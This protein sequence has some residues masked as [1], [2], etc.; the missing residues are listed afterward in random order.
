MLVAGLAVPRL[1]PAV[2]YQH[3][4]SGDYE[5]LDDRGKS[6]VGDG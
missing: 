2:S 1:Y 4:D 3:R 5:P 6:L